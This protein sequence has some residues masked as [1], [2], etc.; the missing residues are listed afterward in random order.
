MTPIT[1]GASLSPKSTQPPSVPHSGWLEK[2]RSPILVSLLL[3]LATFLVFSPA[4]RNDFVNFDD[5]DYVTANPHVKTGLKWDNV[6]WA[7][8]GGHASNWHPLT[9]LSHMFDCQ[10]FNQRAALHH[11]E[12][13]GWHIAN[14][15]LLFLLLN[16]LTR[17]FW[18]SALVAALFALHPL[19]VESVAWVAERKDLLSTFFLLLTLWAYALYGERKSQTSP[20]KQT[21]FTPLNSPIVCYGLA[22]LCYVLGLLSKPMLV[23]APF[24]LLLL[25][26]WPLRRFNSAGEFRARAQTLIAD[27]APFLLL[28]AASSV[29]TFLVQ[30]NS[31]AVWAITDLTLSARIENALVAY[32]RYLAKLVWPA[33]LSVFYPHPGRWPLTM[34]LLAGALLLA[35]SV[36]AYASRRRAPFVLVGWC[37]F[38]GT[39][40]PVIGLVQVG[41]QSMADRYT[42]I[43]YI[44]LFIVLAWGIDEITR[45][46]RTRAVPLVVAASAALL[47]F[48]AITVQ[49]LAHWKSSETLFRH[50]LRVTHHNY[51][52]NHNLAIALMF[53]GRLDEALEHFKEA[54]RLRPKSA[55]SWNGIGEVL[56]R[57]GRLDDAMQ[58]FHRAVEFQADFAVAR[59]NLGVALTRKGLVKEA[60]AEFQ[61]A[62]KAKPD[63]ARAHNNLGMALQSQGRLDEAIPELQ[64][65]V[66]LAPE[67]PEAHNN[68]G[69]A[70]GRKGRVDEAIVQ[71]E[72]ALALN[73]KDPQAHHNLGLA[74]SRQRRFDEAIQQYEL[75]LIWNADSPETHALLGSALAEKGRRAE[76]IAHLQQALK[77]RPG[78]AQAQQ[79]LQ[80]LMSKP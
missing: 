58:F 13:I 61:E 22:L 26:Y 28:A 3:S 10:F 75:A 56:L 16:R 18:R 43:P 32:P 71:L 19:H 49:Q 47:A 35:I 21:R 2:I 33:K 1:Q 53:D 74:L 12:N 67:D 69:M 41:W 77:L 6:V 60:A 42:Y 70:L 79:Q 51:V 68:L 46:W 78:Y 20:L 66:Q 65:S 14:T 44:G 54:L 25:D 57:Q 37:W 31:G 63:Y 5:P 17:G 34:V 9:W 40:V 73:P 23:T 27:K 55:D 4:L 39:L 64:Q 59:N 50:S 7:F 38:L 15:V 62:V 11:L 45:S 30:K 72:R 24:L 80:T 29:T 8:N 48:A 76:A 52:A 36:L